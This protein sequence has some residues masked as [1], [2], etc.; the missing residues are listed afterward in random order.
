[1]GDLEDAERRVRLSA[2]Q[3]QVGRGGCGPEPR[4][5]CEAA[6]VPGAGEGD[7]RLQG[8]AGPPTRRAP[9]PAACV[10]ALA[11]PPPGPARA[12]ARFRCLRSLCRGE[13]IRVC[14]RSPRGAS[15]PGAQR[16]GSA[17]AEVEAEARGQS[18]SRSPEGPLPQALVEAARPTRL[19]GSV[20]QPSA[21]GLAQVMMSGF[22]DGGR[23]GSALRCESARLEGPLPPLC[24]SPGTARA[25]F[26]IS[27]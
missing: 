27:K 14:Q 1:M 7:M 19:G 23:A 18:G 16:T 21:L 17:D 26:Q 10:W 24:P 6:Q 12:S 3:A 5:A 11:L 20:G 13:R 8:K 15:E 9:A 25:L 4:G 2:G 22:W